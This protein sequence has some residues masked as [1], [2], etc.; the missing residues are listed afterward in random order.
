M[1]GDLCRRSNKFLWVNRLDLYVIFLSGI[2]LWD[3][4]ADRKDTQLWLPQ[5][6]TSDRVQLPDV[7]LGFG[8]QRKASRLPRHTSRKD[9]S[10]WI[11]AA[12]GEGTRPNGHPG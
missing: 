1:F 11:V 7:F 5:F 10:F 8:W 4:D 9:P 2:A 6:W 12:T 3:K